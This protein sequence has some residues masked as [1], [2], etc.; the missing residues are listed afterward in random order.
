MVGWAFSALLLM[1]NA[2]RHATG[3]EITA[4]HSGWNATGSFQNRPV[5]A[6]RHEEGVADCKPSRCN[7]CESYCDDM[8]TSLHSANLRPPLFR[9]PERLDR[10]DSFDVRD[11]HRVRCGTGFVARITRTWP[12]PANRAS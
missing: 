11:I 7:S 5:F 3:S 1:K 10:P 12:Q 4:F 8:C 2:E 9:K 6:R